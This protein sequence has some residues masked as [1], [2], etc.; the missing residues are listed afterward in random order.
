MQEQFTQEMGIQLIEICDTM[1]GFSSDIFHEEE[2]EHEMKVLWD[3]LCSPPQDLEQRF[4]PTLSGKS[5]TEPATSEGQSD[6]DV[7]SDASSD[8]DSDSVESCLARVAGRV[9]TRSELGVSRNALTSTLFR[10]S[11]TGMLHYGHVDDSSKTACGRIMG[12][13]YLSFCGD[14]EKAWPHCKMCWGT[15]GP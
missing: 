3:L 8:S 11:R 1:L 2:C 5:G 14:A 15:L 12:P 6:E 10:H 7:S 13:S 4:E 9:G